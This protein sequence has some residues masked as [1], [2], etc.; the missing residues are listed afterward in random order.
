MG[1]NLCIYWGYYL[2]TNLLHALW[3]IQAIVPG[4]YVVSMVGL[5][6][7]A[8]ES[9]LRGLKKVEHILPKGGFYG[10]LPWYK[11]YQAQAAK[12]FT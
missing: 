12:Y 2:L 8:T 10:D 11:T 9:W 6:C 1:C 4:H 3:D 5:A 7:R